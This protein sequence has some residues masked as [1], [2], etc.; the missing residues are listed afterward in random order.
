MRKMATMKKTVLLAGRLEIETER[1]LLAG[2]NPLIC[3]KVEGKHAPCLGEKHLI[4]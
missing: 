4:N 2:G 1:M 3:R